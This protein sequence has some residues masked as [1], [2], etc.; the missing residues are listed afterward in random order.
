MEDSMEGNLRSAYWGLRIGLGASAFLAGL[1]KFTNRLTNWDKYL[2]DEVSE[3]LPVK[4]RNFMRAVGVIEMIVGAGILSP[5]T[6]P[7]SYIA[8]AWLLAIAGNLF[9]SGR[10]FDIAVRDVNMAIA[11]YAL[12]RL[13]ET[14]SSEQRSMPQQLGLKAA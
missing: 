10:W 13:S 5:K 7:S 11:A 6:R 2:S 14:R 3:R 4:D 12:A 8:S 1:D 9:S